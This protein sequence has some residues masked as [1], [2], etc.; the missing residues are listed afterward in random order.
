MKRCL[1]GGLV[2]EVLKTLLS[3]LGLPGPPTSLCATFSCGGMLKTVFVPPLPA[4][5]NDMKDRITAAI[6]TV[7][8]DIL[9][10]AWE[11]IS[12]RLDVVHA[13]GGGHLE[14]L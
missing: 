4:D 8:G 1:S 14:H 9:K 6:N 13:A 12:Y 7:D 5:I 2:E 10:R 3:A 11:E